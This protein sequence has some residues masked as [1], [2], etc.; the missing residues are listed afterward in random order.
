MNIFKRIALVNKISKKVKAVKKYLEY[1]HIDDE[2]KQTIENLKANII[3]LGSI[4]PAA[5]G[6]I[7]DIMELIKS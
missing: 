5:K 1:T 7:E 6:L 3:K 2:I 4:I